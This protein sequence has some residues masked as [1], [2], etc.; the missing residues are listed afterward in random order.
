MFTGF[1]GALDEPP[2]IIEGTYEVASDGSVSVTVEGTR[3]ENAYRLTVVQATDDE[4]AGEVTYS[5]S[6]DVYE[7]EDADTSLLASK[8][9]ANTSPYYYMSQSG[10]F[11]RAVDMPSGAELTY[12]IDIDEDGLYRLDFVYGN[13]QGTDRGNMATH[14]PVN[15]TQSFSLDGGEAVDEVMKSTL[16]QTMTGIKSIYYDLDKGEHTIKIVSG[17]GIGNGMVYHDFLRVTYIGEYGGGVPEYSKTFEAEQGDFNKLVGNE[18]STVLTETKLEGY[19]GSGYITGLADRSVPEGGGVRFTVVVPE[20]AMYDFTLGVHSEEGAKVNIYVGNTAVTLDNIVTT[21]DVG[22]SQD[23]QNVGA[24]IFLEKGINVVDIDG[25]AELDYMRLS[26]GDY[27]D[28]S[29]VFEAEDCIPSELKDSIEVLDSDGASGGKYVAGMAGSYET[30]DYLE[31]IYNAPKAGTYALTVYHSNEDIAGT[32]GYNIKIIDKYAVFEV[33]GESMSPQFDVQDIPEDTRTVYYFVDCG[34]HDP[35]TVSE[36]DE[37][38]ILNTVTDRIYGEDE[39]GYSWG[40]E[41]LL[42]NE[43]ESSSGV[44]GDKA[45]YTTYQRTLT[46]NVKDGQRKESTFRYAHNQYEDGIDPRYVAYKF[47]LDPGKYDVTVGFSNTWGNGSEPTLHLI[48]DGIDEV[49]EEVVLGNGEQLE[50][51]VAVDLS[52]AELNENGRAELVVKATTDTPS[53]QVTYIII[54]EYVEP[55]EAEENIYVMPNG[56]Q[57][58]DIS[59]NLPE[60]VYVGELAEDVIWIMDFRSVKNETNRYFFRN[61]FSDD[62][63]DEKTIYVDLVEGENTIKIF[64][65]N[66]WNVT[67]GGSTETPATEYLENYTPNF[68]KFVITPVSL[69][70]PGELPEYSLLNQRPEA[71][72]DG[73]PVAA[74]TAGIV[75]LVAAAVILITVAARSRK[76]TSK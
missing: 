12:T 57:S 59:Q 73:V 49:T 9:D 26:A 74:A 37:F 44:A 62:T 40:V 22:A 8:T 43:Y 69:N 46:E 71:D 39:T 19:S 50:R 36:G 60:D 33:N 42:D 5:S 52:G 48:S 55:T 70:D 72:S 10:E 28:A 34:D 31:L 27:L 38:G 24:V 54:R 2:V 29:T 63:F 53:V 56:T 68:D 11:A 66:S 61:S 23:W 45:V 13:G 75:I 3:F 58:I 25:T 4:V 65:D 15:V 41:I 47:E 76:K 35:S 64:N 17:E 16:W 67:F 30:P 20:S 6:G 21:I 7:A 18:D 32:H 51:S 14:D 1:H